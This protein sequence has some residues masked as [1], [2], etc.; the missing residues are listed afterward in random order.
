MSRCTAVCVAFAVSLVAVSAHAQSDETAETFSRAPNAFPHVLD[1][2]KPSQIPPR[3]LENSP[4]LNDLLHDGTLRLPLSQA[5]A[6][7]IENNLDI[8]VQRFVRPLAEADVLRTSSGQ[9]AR[10][11]PGALVPSGLSA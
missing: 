7:A 10:G 11:I 6:L 1:P 5:L 8:A 4:R 2:Y 3:Q 9:A